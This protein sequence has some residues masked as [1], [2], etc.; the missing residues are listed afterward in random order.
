MQSD[1]NYLCR[2]YTRVLNI[3]EVEDFLPENIISMLSLS[4]SLLILCFYFALKTAD[5]VSQ[6]QVGKKYS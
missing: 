6:S 3:S 1:S 4:L 5:L 2:Y